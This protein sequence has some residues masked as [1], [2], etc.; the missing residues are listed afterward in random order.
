MASD[1]RRDFSKILAAAGWS[2]AGLRATF[3]CE[4]SFRLEFYLFLLLVPTA[5]WLA[6][7]PLQLWMLISCMVLVLAMEIVNSAIEA[8]VD[9]VVGDKQHVLAG[10]AK[11][12]GSAAVFL[13]M[14]LV[15]FTWATVIYQNYFQSG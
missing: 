10:R 1:E 12:M 13:C 11:D 7:T 9:L 2:W 15:V 5:I 4:A 6:K 8:T 3:R 14:L